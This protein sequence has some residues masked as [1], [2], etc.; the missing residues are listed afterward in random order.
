MRDDAETGAE[1]AR[2]R[3]A[4]I[5]RELAALRPAAPPDR[6]PIA[7]VV[8]IYNDWPA[9]RHLAEAIDAVCEA[10]DLDAEVIVVDDG[11]W[12]SGEETLAALARTAKRVRLRPAILVTNLGHQRAIAVGLTLASERAAAYGAV[13][14]MDGDGEDRPEHIPLLLRESAAHPEAIVCVRRGRRFEG[15]RFAIGYAAFKAA[16]ALA[17]GKTI[18]FGHYCV[19]PPRALTR[20]VHSPALWSHFAAALLRAGVPL[21]RVRLDRGVR[22]AGRSSMNLTSLIRH[23]LNAIAVFEDVCLV[24]L[25]IALGVFSAGIC[26]ALIGVVAVR[27]GTDLAIPGWATSAAGLLLVALLQAA[28]LA[29]T[30]AASH[31]N[32]RSLS[33]MVPARDAARFLG[34]AAPRGGAQPLPPSGETTWKAAS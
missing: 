27:F 20:L 11:S 17:T 13:I 25:L 6:R 12:Q 24:R 3:F 16:F 8:P 4:E 23:G 30:S 19:I 9:F 10:A 15:L 29:I 18:D 33:E 34:P 5:A 22:Y 7:V 26:A 32:R 21:H 28:L 1:A 14:V 2:D 31:L